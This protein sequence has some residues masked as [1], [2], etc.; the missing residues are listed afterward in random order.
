I[1]LASV[2]QIEQL[3]TG[4]MAGWRSAV[5]LRTS[6]RAASQSAHCCALFCPVVVTFRQTGC[7]DVEWS[8]R[9]AC[10]L[11]P[12]PRLFCTRYVPIT[13]LAA[14]VPQMRQVICPGG[15]VWEGCPRQNDGVS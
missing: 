3:N 10:P 11:L 7:L 12:M 13:V 4:R 2:C 9:Y 1:L 8:A 6:R 15:S 5:T 14:S